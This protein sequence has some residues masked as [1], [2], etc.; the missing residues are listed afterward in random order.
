M[1]STLA[2]QLPI[3]PQ[4]IPQV[5]P[6]TQTSQNANVVGQAIPPP[7]VNVQPPPQGNLPLPQQNMT[8]PN[9][10]ISIINPGNS[11]LSNNNALND[12][13]ATVLKGQQ[14]WQDHAINVMSSLATK[15]DNALA[16][17]AVPVFT[18]KD[19]TIKIEDWIRA[20]EKAALLTDLSEKR[21]ALQKTRGTPSRY[22]ENQID[23]SWAVIKKTLESWYA[24]ST[25]PINRFF[26]LDRKPQRANETLHDY[27]QR[28]MDNSQKATKGKTPNQ[29]SDEV[30]RAM[31]I[32][33]LFN[34]HIKCKVHDYP[35]VKTL[36]DAFNAARA[37]R[38]KLK[39][40]EDVE[41]I[42]DSDDDSDSNLSKLLTSSNNIATL[43]MI[44]QVDM[45]IL[46]AVMAAPCNTQFELCDH[47]VHEVNN[48]LPIQKQLQQQG[49]DGYCFKCGA[50]GY[51]S[52]HCDTVIPKHTDDQGNVKINIDAKAQMRYIPFT[53]QDFD[54]KSPVNA[55]NYQVTP[56]GKPKLTQT[57]QSEYLLGDR[58]INDFNER[59]NSYSQ[60]L[61]QE[62]SKQNVVIVKGMNTLG[63]KISKWAPSKQNNNNKRFTKANNRKM[64]KFADKNPSNRKDDDGNDSTQ[65]KAKQVLTNVMSQTQQIKHL[66]HFTSDDEDSVSA[67]NDQDSSNTL[68][69]N[70]Y[71]S[72]NDD[73]GHY[74][75]SEG[76]SCDLCPGTDNTS[77][78]E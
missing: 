53:N 9:H 1:S 14:E 12:T 36:A 19:K 45:Q 31:F 15:Q 8:N 10:N 35:N 67:N 22:I 37:V 33:G 51:V 4:S 17:E 59:I 29:I 46:D 30:Y 54:P 11:V 77:A 40:Y 3:Q 2:V 18:G 6:T 74:Q 76:D 64:V 72:Q 75:S 34:K 70:G 49:F 7:P 69:G 56:F 48:M 63:K 68:T 25:Q 20:V 78:E 21:I 32:K 27:I 23:A 60:Q 55:Q 13:L 58:H 66:L 57:V 39:R 50:Y 65:D 52:R 43:Q 73:Y 38:N 41:G 5:Y 71:Q 24:C 28:F 16:L 61:S 42:I 44:S 62:L 47:Y 26:N